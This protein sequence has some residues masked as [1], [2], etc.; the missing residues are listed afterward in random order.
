MD[1]QK[2][3]GDY[4]SI[5]MMYNEYGKLIGSPR[6][7]KKKKEKGGEG[8]KYSNSSFDA[9]NEVRIQSGTIALESRSVYCGGYSPTQRRKSW[10]KSC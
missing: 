5:F 4:W 9:G 3:G 8:K 7:V 1:N 6:N 2:R 10:L